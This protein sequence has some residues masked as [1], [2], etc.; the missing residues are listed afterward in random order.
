MV[1]TRIAPSPTGSLHIGGL[2]MALYDYAL[3]KKNNGKFIL[4]IEDT[5]RNRFAEGAEAEAIAMLYA[6]GFPYD[7]VY[8][9]S[10]RL[11]LYKEYAEKLIEK[12]FAYYCFSTKEEIEVMRQK[13]QAEHKT[14]IFRSPYRDLPIE[15][16]CKKIENGQEYVIRQ[17]LQENQVVEFTDPVQGLMQFNT[18]DIDE[19]VLL[20]S[21]GFPTYHLAVV[22]DDHLMGVTHVFRGVEWLPS[23]P[24]HV[25]LYKAFDWEMP[26]ISHLSV[27]LDP[28]GGKLS[29]RKGSVSAKDFLDEGYLPEAV[30]NFLM[31]LG[32]SPAIKYGFGEK[33]REIF[34]LAEFIEL[35]DMTDVNKASP[36]F[37]REK[38]IWFNQK[39]IQA[40][41]G[42][43][44]VKRFTDWL[45]PGEEYKG[46]L[47]LINSRGD[48]YLEKVLLL[49]QTRVK[50]LSD[51]TETI[52]F[53]YKFKGGTDFLAI[54][55]TKNLTTEQIKGFFKESILLFEKYPDTLKDLN[56]ESLEMFVREYAE[57]NELKAGSLFMALR[58]ATTDSAFSPPLLEVIRILG[59][60]EII[61]RIASY[62]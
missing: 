35:F 55:Q 22:V 43:E 21:D 12:G 46:L 42:P 60:Q 4:R 50:L 44:L 36:V 2:K 59:K 17:K 56:R 40:L 51:F 53:F 58:L 29:K 34:S 41:S 47:E 15:E 1:V 14:F 25:L 7:E 61:K 32:W 31:L 19:T 3:A 30:L 5:D 18:N 48:D 27:I 45:T 57:K 16:A 28:D 10:E 52:E 26:V 13:A 33:E 39:Y 20:K 54:K 38:L 37:N 6:Y 8:K 24:K 11:S 23:V 9:Q 49:E 62:L